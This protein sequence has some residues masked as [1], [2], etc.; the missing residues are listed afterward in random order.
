MDEKKH[1]PRGILIY[2]KKMINSA[3]VDGSSNKIRTAFKRSYSF[4]A[5]EYR[6]TIIYVVAGGLSLLTIN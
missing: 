3:V 6:D 5:L 2:I 4:K 1:F